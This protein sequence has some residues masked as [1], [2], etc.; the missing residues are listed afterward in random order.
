MRLALQLDDHQT[1]PGPGTS[2]PPSVVAALGAAQGARTPLGTILL[3]N[4]AI[5]SAD[6]VRAL[7]LQTRQQARLGDI[8]RAHGLASDR[9]VIGALGEQFG[10]SVIDPA[11]S[12]PDPRLIDLL[13][14]RRCLQIACLPWS[15]AGGCTLVA[16]AQPDRFEDHR[17]ELETA[18]GPVVMAV[19]AEADLHAT[20]IGLRRSTLRLMAETCVAAKES[21]RMW[22]GRRFSRLAAGGLALILAATLL[23]P[24]ATF[25]AL[26][27]L[28]VA[29]MLAGN[30]MKI[31]AATVALFAPP[32]PGGAR[33][34]PPLAD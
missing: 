3:R 29:F 21:C 13:G 27:G 10:T 23:A 15:R 19:I 33:G 31:A 12:R 32:R 8:L 7:A 14:P 17:A 18:L 34:R 16:C 2:T 25:L 5:S 30:A 6:L 26:F 24:L 9:A 4:G 28:V 20:L 11:L 22:D 1:D